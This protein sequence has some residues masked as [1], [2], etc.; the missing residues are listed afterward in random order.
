MRDWCQPYI[1]R[2]MVHPWEKPFFYPSIVIFFALLPQ[3]SGD[4]LPLCQTAER[5]I[6]LF[7][8]DIRKITQNL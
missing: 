5:K 1:V 2:I 3:E 7:S 6:F 8:T 4:L